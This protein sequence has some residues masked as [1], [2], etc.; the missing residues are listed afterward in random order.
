MRKGHT[1]A[2]V[3]RTEWLAAAM[4]GDTYAPIARMEDE[5]PPGAPTVDKAGPA[6]TAAAPLSSWTA[7]LIACTLS[8]P[9]SFQKLKRECIC[10]WQRCLCLACPLIY[11]ADAN[12]ALS[13]E[14]QLVLLGSPP[15]LPALLTKMTPCLLTTCEGVFL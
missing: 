6:S 12:H 11:D 13:C 9:K 10:L 8:Q 3:P 4:S 2:M 15:A 7:K 5:V 14:R 1:S